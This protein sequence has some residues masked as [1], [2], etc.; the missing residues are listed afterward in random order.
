MAKKKYRDVVFRSSRGFKMATHYETP[1]II[2]MA[3]VTYFISDYL[4][5]T[6]IIFGPGPTFITYTFFVTFLIGIGD[7]I[8][9]TEMP[10]IIQNTQMEG[11][12]NVF[13]WICILQDSY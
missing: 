5:D 2:I 8:Y 1:L 4:F 9:I 11:Q 3:I 6:I 7:S 13:I 10:F 12:V